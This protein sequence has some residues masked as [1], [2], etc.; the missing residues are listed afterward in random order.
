MLKNTPK[1]QVI[2][3]QNH[4]FN[5]KSADR[6]LTTLSAPQTLSVV[7]VAVKNKTAD[8][9]G[10]LS[11]K[12][13]ANADIT[14]L[15]YSGKLSESAKAQLKS[16]ILLNKKCNFRGDIAIPPF[17]FIENVVNVFKNKTDIPLEMPLIIGINYVA[18]ELL[19][20]NVNI[21][22]KEQ[23]IKPD[24]W[25]ILLARSG[26]GKT[27]T[28]NIFEKAI[29]L[30]NIFDSGVQS[31]AKFIES[32]SEN[33]H[34]IFFKDEIG[35]LLKA[36]KNQ[37]YMEEEKEYLLKIYDNKTIMRKTKDYEITVDDPAL[38]ILGM[39]AYDSFLTNVSSEDIVDGFAARFN[40][41]IAKQDDS[42]P[43]LSVPL[44]PTG[45]LI[46][47]VKNS[48]K[49]LKFPKDNTAYTLNK[50]A[51]KAFIDSF[52][53]YANLE[54]NN[55]PSAFLRRTLYKSLKYA[56][57]YHIIL[58]KSKINEIDGEDVGWAMRLIFM[59]IEDIKELLE[60]YGFSK[61]ENTVQK[62][63]SLKKKFKESGKVLKVRDIVS[64]IRE[65]RTVN[66]ARN[67]LDI[68]E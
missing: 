10:S 14:S 24:I 8:K 60:E 40:Y 28:H 58:G 52:K 55:I 21:N 41:I 7:S 5:V 57:I 3:N 26:D 56:L 61:L 34:S 68:I 11:L 1:T 2:T 65:I 37:S 46:K 47:T 17:S 44:Y 54:N 23:Y 31:A 50:K 48:W 18:A 63:E 33:N 20:L 25:T 59:H 66:E 42:R 9:G 53:N 30:E 51:E 62:I 16:L 38:I 6:L 13:P 15:V 49:K 45:T 32:V 19:K 4:I 29:K 36:L 43:P 27:Y 64:N 39:N 22:F 35:Q 67:I 12:K